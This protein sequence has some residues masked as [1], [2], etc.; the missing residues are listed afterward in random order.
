MFVFIES[1]VA[2]AAEQ[3]ALLLG[4]AAPMLHKVEEELQRDA[5]GFGGVEFFA[6]GWGWG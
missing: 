3:C 1:G 2:D 5:A 4:A 6:W